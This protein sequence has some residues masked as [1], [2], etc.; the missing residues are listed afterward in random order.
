MDD[1]RVSRCAPGSLALAATVRQFAGSRLEQQLLS[2]VFDLLWQ[3]RSDATA[4][5]A[6]E[7]NRQPF[8]RAEAGTGSFTASPGS[9]RAKGGRR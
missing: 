3:A 5:D 2:Q 9:V 6:P 7:D 4:V 1:V 8:A